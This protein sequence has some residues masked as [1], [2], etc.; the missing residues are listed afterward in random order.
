MGNQATTI[1]DITDGAIYSD[2]LKSDNGPW[3]RNRKAFTF[4]INSDGISVSLKS[5][6]TIWPVYLVI[7]ELPS[8]KRFCIDNVI[9]AGN[10]F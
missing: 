7:N 6:L 4:M 9:I 3:L 5:K 8:E 1:S 2:F 10:Y